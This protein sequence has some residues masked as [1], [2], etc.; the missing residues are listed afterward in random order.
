AAATETLANQTINWPQVK[1]EDLAYLNMTS[2]STGKP[3]AAMAT[4]GQLHGNTKACVQRFQM[5]EKDI[6][7]PLLAVM[8]HPH[9]IFCRALFTGGSIVLLENLYPRRISE[10]IQTHRVTCI[11]AVSAVYKLL[12]PFLSSSKYDF[13]S[14]R[15]PESG[16]MSTS[17]ALITRF[18]DLTGTPVIPVWG[19]TETMGVAFASKLDGSSPRGSVGKVLQGYKVRIVDKNNEPVQPGEIGEMQLGGRG[20]MSGYWENPCETAKSFLDKWYRSGDLFEVDSKGNHFFRGRMDAMIKVGGLKIYPAEIEAALFAHPLIREAVVVPFDDGLR[21][22]VPLAVLVTEPG[23]SLTESHLRSFLKS[24]LTKT[25]MP[26]IFRFL[27]DFPRTASG[28]IDRKALVS[29]SSLDHK[30]SEVSL[31]SRQDAID[32]K[33]LHLLNERMRIE[34]KLMKSQKYK[35]FQ[36]ERIQEIIQRILEFNPGPL[37]DSIIEKLFRSILSLRTLY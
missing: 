1:K 28:K 34:I 18:T 15:L 13:S 7:L 35:G 14:L 27:P 31:E 10:M 32:L 11:M 19:S 8:S 3:K 26:R 17:P 30:P 6:H 12:I 2:G 37:H 23:E 16:G 9:E 22:L 21:G 29:Y 20:I 24:R 5:T 33:I 4:F 25:K 36:P